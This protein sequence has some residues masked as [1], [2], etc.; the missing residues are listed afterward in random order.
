M[1]RIGAGA[2]SQDGTGLNSRV[3]EWLSSFHRRFRLAEVKTPKN[4]AWKRLLD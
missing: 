1:P 2:H 3:K 4:A